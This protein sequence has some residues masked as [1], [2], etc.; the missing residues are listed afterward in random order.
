MLS[1]RDYM[2]PDEPRGSWGMPRP[3]GGSVIKPLII[4]NI[5]VFCLTGFGHSTPTSVNPLL[6]LIILHPIYIRQ[7][8]IWR[9]GTYMFAHAGFAH[10]FFNMWALYMFGT[11]VEQ[12]LGS[13]RFLRL[14]LISGLVGGLAWLAATWWQPAYFEILVNGRPVQV[15]G[16]SLRAVAHGADARVLRVY[17]GVIGAS[18][19]VFGVMMAAAMTFPNDLVLLLFPPVPMKMKTLVFVF[20][21]IEVLMTWQQTTGHA[22]GRIAHLAH[23][24]GLV[25]AFFYLK[26]LGHRGPAQTLR[27]WY[28]GV[29]SGFGRHSPAAPPPVDFPSPAVVD[30]ILDK[31]GEHGIESLTPEERRILEQQ[32][33]KLKDR[34][35]R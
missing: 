24:G 22:M 10:L 6:E 14:Y 27:G 4:A 3:R 16:T 34:D 15:F 28:R 26:H 21:S 18:G 2:R 5:I 20:A 25:G 19:A 8:E 33:K 30:R 13:T 23:L 7:F 31:I 35:G 11:R 32:G 17:G 12:R 29:A 9:L 1:D